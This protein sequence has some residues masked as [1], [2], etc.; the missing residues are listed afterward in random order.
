MTSITPYLLYRSC[1]DALDV[2][3]RAFGFDEVLRSTGAEENWG[4][5]R[6]D[7]G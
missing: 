5:T 3:H 1:E 7:V 2:L 4:A 6:A